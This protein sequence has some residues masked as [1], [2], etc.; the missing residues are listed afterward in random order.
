MSFIRAHLTA[1]S[2]S[3]PVRVALVF[4]VTV[5][6]ALTFP[7]VVHLAR[8]G[9]GAL[10]ILPVLLAGWLLG[11][12]TGLLVGLLIF[13][14]NTL[15]YNFTGEPGWDVLIR[16]GGAMPMAAMVLIGAVIGRVHDLSE[17]LRQQLVER[18]LATQALGESEERY[19][20][21]VTTS[22]DAVISI[23]PQMRVT[24]WNPGAESIFG[25]T[26]A[27]MLGQTLIRIIPHKYRGVKEKGFTRFV[28]SG[29][30]PVIGKTV[31][32]EGLRKDGDEVPVELSISSRMVGGEYLATAIVRDITER[33]RTEEDLWKAKEIAEAA[34]QAKSEFLANMSHEIRTPMNG[35]IGMTD[36]V[37][38]TE[39]SLEQ[40]EYLEMARNSADTLLDLLNDILDLSKVEAG[41][42]ALEEIPFNLY[43]SVEKTAETLA[44]RAQRKGLELICHLRPD[45]PDGLVGDP[46][47]LRQVLVNLVGNAIKFTE[48]GEVVVRVEREGG[49]RRGGIAFL[50][51]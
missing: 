35:I 44:L 33:K 41:R 9:A 1:L 42:L 5:T 51:V 43:T 20:K 7:L 45:V 21:L 32:I 37:L 13:P 23:D 31:E 39:L 25:Y 36:L 38:D 48:E 17:R 8:G 15:L 3:R 14:L 12:R 16:L 34:T 47:R 18:T 11:F 49:R 30:G 46:T 27:E 50:G 2:P 19:R 29:T 4:G 24:L 6:Y 40:R 22:V 28:E 26:E 10:A